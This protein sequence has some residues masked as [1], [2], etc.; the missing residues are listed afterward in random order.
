[1]PDLR[2]ARQRQ[3]AARGGIVLYAFFEDG[4]P[5]AQ[6]YLAAGQKE[7]AG[8]L[9]RNAVGMVDQEPRAAER[10]TSTAATSTGR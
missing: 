1:V 7:Q 9:F 6:C 10:S 5:G 3:D 2:R 8:Y 4:E